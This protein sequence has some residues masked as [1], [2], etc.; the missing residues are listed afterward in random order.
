LDIASRHVENQTFEPDAYYHL[1]MIYLANGYKE[2]ARHYLY[3][4]LESEFELGP[5]V[6]KKINAAIQSL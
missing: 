6:T 5:S 4:A 2:Q 1:G 3:E